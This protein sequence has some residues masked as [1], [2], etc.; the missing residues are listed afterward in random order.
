MSVIFY[1]ERMPSPMTYLK[2]RQDL[3]ENMALIA[4]RAGAIAASAMIFVAFVLGGLKSIFCLVG[5]AS[6]WFPTHQARW[7]LCSA[8]LLALYAYWPS[9]HSALTLSVGYLIALQSYP[10]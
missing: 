7:H 4:L 3:G 9:L 2:F 8:L 5:R 10:H 6:A 1:L